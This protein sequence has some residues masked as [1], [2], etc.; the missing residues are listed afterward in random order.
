MVIGLG[1]N[2]LNPFGNIINCYQNIKTLKRR[3][4]VPKIDVSTVKYFYNQ[5]WV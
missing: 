5:N 3:E 4:I 2:V 1:W